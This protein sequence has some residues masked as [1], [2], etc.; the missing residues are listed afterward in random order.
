MELFVGYGSRDDTGVGD[1]EAS[2]GLEQRG[3]LAVERLPITNMQN[4]VHG[5][6]AVERPEAAWQWVVQVCYL[7]REPGLHA[8]FDSARVADFDC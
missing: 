3:D 1:E 5:K 6:R 2:S 8:E 4:N 7:G